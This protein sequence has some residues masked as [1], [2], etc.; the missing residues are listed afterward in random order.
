MHLRATSQLT[1]ILY[2]KLENYTLR[3][4]KVYHDS[5]LLKFIHM[6][7]IVII[8]LGNGLVSCHFLIKYGHVCCHI[9]ASHGPKKQHKD[10]EISSAVWVMLYCQQNENIT[11]IIGIPEDSKSYFTN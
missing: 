2:I 7:P 11:P 10:C 1:A 9:S 8:D 3:K 5:N 6:D 4:K